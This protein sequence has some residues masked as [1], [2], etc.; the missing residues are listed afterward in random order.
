VTF[1]ILPK[2]SDIDATTGGEVGVPIAGS[3]TN[4]LRRLFPGNLP[5]NRFKKTSKGF[6]ELKRNLGGET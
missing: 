1:S 5:P 6:K 4:E 2:V 3:K